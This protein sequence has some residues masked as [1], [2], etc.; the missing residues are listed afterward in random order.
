[1][2]PLNFLFPKRKPQLVKSRTNALAETVNNVA[3]CVL[4]TSALQL[5]F[6][7]QTTPPTVI[8][9]TPNHPTTQP[10]NRPPPVIAKE[11]TQ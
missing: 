4:A 9:K 11:I 7:T 10:T 1:L 3:N 2:L 5:S 8:T 6:G